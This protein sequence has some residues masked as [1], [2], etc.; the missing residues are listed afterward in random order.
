MTTAE[1]YQLD[2]QIGFLLRQAL[3]RNSEIFTKE[4]PAGLT[5]TRFAALAK[6]YEFGALSQNELGRHTAMDVATIKG[7]VDHLCKF[8]LVHRTDDPDDGRKQQLR[9]SEQGLERFSVVAG[10]A[11]RV[12]AMTLRELSPNEAGHLLQLLKKVAAVQPTR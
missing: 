5:P 11:H 6:L 12:S 7:V 4:M 3:Q 1:D 9:L 10:S 2:E 8:G